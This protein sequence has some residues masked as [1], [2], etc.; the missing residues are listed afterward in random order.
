MPRT[1]VV[2]LILAVVAFVGL[3][4]VSA[5]GSRQVTCEVCVEFHGRSQC[6]S[7]TGNEPYETTRVA[8]DNACSFVAS[9]R[10]EMI[11]C[12]SLPP[13]KVECHER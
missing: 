9:G 2:G 13:S 7:A 8:T 4:I 11:Q 3:T 12:N 1:V 10:L 6:R 5:L